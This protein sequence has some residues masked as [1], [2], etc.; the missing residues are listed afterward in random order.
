M[1]L[2]QRDFGRRSVCAALTDQDAS[3]ALEADCRL[4]VRE[5]LR[6]VVGDEHIAA[7]RAGTESRMEEFLEPGSTKVAQR[8]GCR[9]TKRA[10]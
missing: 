7:A 5:L 4:I 6:R 1:A 8:R 10:D 2:L 3:N 9:R